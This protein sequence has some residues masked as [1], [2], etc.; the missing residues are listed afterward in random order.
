[1]TDAASPLTPGT[2]FE[3]AT[4]ITV[5]ETGPQRVVAR[6]TLGPANH[7]PWGIVHGGTYASFVE[8]VAS[9]GASAAV[10]AD[11]KVAVGLSNTTHF[12]RALTA[13]EVV[14]TGEPVFQG[15]THQLWQVRV[16]DEQDRLV[17]HGEVRLQNIDPPGGR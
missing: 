11:G 3:H 14:V 1:M 9:I 15:R 12:L 10:A 2:T 13:G 4:T 17:A 6:A 7:T 5:D 8:T 16:V